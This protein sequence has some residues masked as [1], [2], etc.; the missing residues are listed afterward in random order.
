MPLFCSVPVLCNVWL[1]VKVLWADGN[2]VNRGSDYLKPDK[3]FNICLLLSSFILKGGSLKKLLEILQPNKSWVSWWW[4]VFLI[5]LDNISVFIKSNNGYIYIT[6]LFFSLN[7]VRNVSSRKQ[8]SN[9]QLIYDHLIMSVVV[10]EKIY[11]HT[12]VHV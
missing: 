4:I 8:T 6:I 12:Y 7:N 2:D 1:L 5:I 11:I 3:L 9:V 10:R